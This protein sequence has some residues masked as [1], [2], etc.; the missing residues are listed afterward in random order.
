[1]KEICIDSV[2]KRFEQHLNIEDNNRIIFSGKFGTGKTYFLNKFFDERPLTYNKFI[3]SPANYVV[4]SNEDIFEI[5]KADI[6]KDLFFTN[7]IKERKSIKKSKLQKI[8]LFVGENPQHLIKFIT[9]SFKKVNPFFEIADNFYDG[10]KT[11]IE[12]FKKY[13]K[14]LEKELQTSEEILSEFLNSFLDTKGSLFEHDFFTRTINSVLDEIRESGT[15]KNVLIIDDLDRID[16]DHIFRILNVLS[17]H[18][19]HFGVENKFEFDHV[20]IVC[21]ID[22][23]QKIFAHKYGDQV[24]FDGYMDK[25]YSAD[26]FVFRNID[27]VNFYVDSFSQEFQSEE[28]KCFVKLIFQC[29]CQENII[30]LRKLLKHRIKFSIPDMM[31][32]EVKDYKIGFKFSQTKIIKDNTNLRLTTKDF[33]IL[34]ILKLLSIS[35]GNLDFLVQKIQTG[36]NYYKLNFIDDETFEKAIRYLALQRHMT[37]HQDVNLFIRVNGERNAYGEYEYVRNVES[38]QTSLFNIT[39]KF[40]T[41][42]NEYLKYSESDYFFDGVSIGYNQDRVDTLANAKNN[43]KEFW[44]TF[45]QIINASKS[46]KYLEKVG[47]I[48]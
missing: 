14:D 16:P 10:L 47:I 37:I 29:L 36:K 19:D 38:P 22:N 32:L 21:D 6:V 28:E 48:F 9:S 18:N 30:T 44:E 33:R 1:M 35:L 43:S 34:E 15:K 17:A 13:E 20:I 11:I 4:S 12:E 40:S 42:W 5:I 26:Y 23:I 2:A 27:A 8:D 7:K 31:L 39:F 24:D 46:K 45:I 25:F 3:I 41:K